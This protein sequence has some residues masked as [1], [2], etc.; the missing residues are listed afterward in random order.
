MKENVKDIGIYLIKSSLAGIMI[1]IGGTIFLSMSNKTIGAIFFSIGLFM[2][3]T[4][5]FKL[6]TGKV[7][8]IF[9]NNLK[10]AFEVLITIIGNFIGTFLVGYILKFTRIYSVVN[11][12]AISMCNVK[13]EDSIIS[14]FIL[15]IFCGILM[16][17][18]VNGYKEVKDPVGKY[19]SVIF[20]VIVF[21]LCGFE[22]SIANMYYFSVA[23]LLGLKTFGYLLVMILGN[24][25]GGVMIPLCDK[26]KKLLKKEEA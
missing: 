7:G 9:N 25:L 6:Y 2:I 15:S 3:V 1:A 14:I 16:Y 24:G 11:E 19:I 21:I 18:A 4:N 26:L 22:H 23:S 12:K 5:G 10:Y 8:Y 20:P 17:L 13:L